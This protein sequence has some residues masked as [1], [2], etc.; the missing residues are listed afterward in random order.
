MFYFR[1]IVVYSLT[2]IVLTLSQ[3]TFG[4]PAYSDFKSVYEKKNIPQ[5]KIISHQINDC[6]ESLKDEYRYFIARGLYDDLYRNKPEQTIVTNDFDVILS[7]LPDFWAATADMGDLSFKARNFI[8]AQKYYERAL[9]DFSSAGKKQEILK[10]K[11]DKDNI[12]VSYILDLQNKAEN[13]RLLASLNNKNF[14]EPIRTR[15][16]KLEGMHSFQIRGVSISGHKYP[17]LF[18][19][20]KASLRSDKANIKNLGL[21]AETLKTNGSPPITIYGHTDYKGS[22]TYNKQLSIKRAK[23][24][25]QFLKN[26]KHYRGFI[27]IK[28]MGKTSPIKMHSRRRAKL[29][30]K[31]WRAIN[32]R[33]E[34]IKNGN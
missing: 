32:R 18:D 30:D 13:A 3:T 19:Y 2:T 15:S 26:D 7:I 21:L 12:P 17:I 29:T 14:I 20:N 22:D 10:I 16:G 9:L 33:V 34:I 23:T 28:G 1:K 11:E 24:I 25:E 6:T 5:L 4:C 8:L 31:E 27:S